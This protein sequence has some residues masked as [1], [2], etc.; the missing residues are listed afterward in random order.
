[1]RKLKFLLLLV[2]ISL[3]STV[4]YAQV[5]ETEVQEKV[6]VQASD[7]PDAV[8]VTLK[9]KYAEYKVDKALQTEF[10]N[11]KAFYVLLSKGEESIKIL[12]DAEGNIYN[13]E[14]EEDEK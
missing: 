14:E 7:L 8:A 11:K 9:E 1:M 2:V 6:A 3:I 13:Q 10:N 4:T 5:E 12:I